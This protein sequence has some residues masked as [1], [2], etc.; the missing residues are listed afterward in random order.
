VYKVGLPEIVAER[1]HLDGMSYEVIIPYE[2]APNTYG[3]DR[4]ARYRFGPR[5]EHCLGTG[6]HSSGSTDGVTCRACQGWGVKP[7]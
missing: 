3:P 6:F 7:V 1:Q 4:L 2:V 5:C